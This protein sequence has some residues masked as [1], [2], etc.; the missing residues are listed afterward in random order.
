MVWQQEPNSCFWILGENIFTNT[1][2][3]DG[4]WLKTYTLLEVGLSGFWVIFWHYFG[5]TFP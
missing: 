5:S 1:H 3:F 2:S 4:W